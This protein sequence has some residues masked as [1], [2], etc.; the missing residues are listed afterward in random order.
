MAGTQ[1]GL[2]NQPT[3]T[4]A[5]DEEMRLTLPEATMFIV[6]SSGALWVLLFGLVNVFL[7]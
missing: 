3:S 2:L 7:G 5:D 6:A 1:Q 4:M